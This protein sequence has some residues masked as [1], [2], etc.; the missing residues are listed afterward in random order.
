M[1]QLAVCHGVSL[2][3]HCCHYGPGCGLGYS[4]ELGGLEGSGAQF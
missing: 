3:A 4:P 2:G 1:T